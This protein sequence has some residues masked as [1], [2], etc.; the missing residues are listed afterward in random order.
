M[1]R[2]I[3]PFGANCIII[4]VA[5][6]F[7]LVQSLIGLVSQSVTVV[8][9]NITCTVKDVNTHESSVQLNLVCGDK[10][11]STRNAETVVEYIKHPGPL[12]CKIYGAG[13]PKCVPLE[14]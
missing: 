8:E 11:F 7:T 1:K 4:F 12:S 9:Q 13:S 10:R 5:F 3:L 14:K 2:F 6:L